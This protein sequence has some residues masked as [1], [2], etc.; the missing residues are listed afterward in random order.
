[1]LLGNEDKYPLLYLR[2]WPCQTVSLD[3]P[4]TIWADRSRER[5]KI[6]NLLKYLVEV[7]RTTLHLM[8]ADL[9]GG[10]SHTLKFIEH[11]CTSEYKSV[12][13]VHSQIPTK[14]TSFHDAYKSI[15]ASFKMVEISGLFRDIF[16]KHGEN[17]TLDRV[18][19]GKI[20]FF[21]ALSAVSLGSTDLRQIGRRWLCGEKEITRSELKTIGVNKVLKGS[22]D[23]VESL[24]AFTRIVLHSEKYSRL[25]LMIDEYQELHATSDSISTNINEGLK[26]Y[27][28]TVPRGLSIVLSFSFEKKEDIQYILSD[29]LSSRE[30]ALR[31]IE[32]PEL[33]PLGASLFIHDLL[34][35]YRTKQKPPWH[36]YPLEPGCIDVI[37]EDV[38]EK[39]VK[40][41]PREIMKR[42]DY[43]LEE[44][45]RKAE[46]GSDPVL[47]EAEALKLLSQA[48]VIDK[49]KV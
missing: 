8:W 34:E 2:D 36:V 41:S 47:S 20:D 31:S 43:L 9:G 11:L 21:K 27:Y 5:S 6:D 15:I 46:N 17:Y 30:D 25:L 45:R 13:P 16:A 3:N 12:F 38:K 49:E 1:M 29:R 33:G 4:V 7:D 26:K 37:I 40:L 42:L 48:K 22:E 10:K 32:L 24:L 23:A 19:H 44:S 28:D 39:R 18:L 35:A 14:L